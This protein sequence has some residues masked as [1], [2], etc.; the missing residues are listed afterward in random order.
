MK[1][2]L[3]FI[4]VV[5]GFLSCEK[6][7]QEPKATMSKTAVFESEQGIELYSNS[8]YNLLPTASDIAYSS[9][10]GSAASSAPGG[11]IIS[12]Y[13]VRR[14]VPD[15]IRPGAF[16]ARQSSGWDWSQ[17]RNIN[18]FIENLKASSL[19]PEVK[20]NYLGLAR[21]FRAWF[22]FQKVLRF[23]DVPWITKA[24]DVSDPDLFK[25]RDSRFLVMDSLLVDID[26]AIDNI[27]LKEDASR[28]LITKYI[29]LAFKS[30]V[31]LFEGTFRKYHNDYG[32]QGTSNQWLEHAANAAKIV[33]DETNFS[34]HQGEEA[35][36]E[37][38]ISNSPIS[39]EVML[40]THYD[41]GLGILHAANWYWTSATYGVRGSFSRTFVNT[42]LNIDGTP[43]TDDPEYKTT[44]FQEETKNR[45]LR[46]K[47]TI[48]TKDYGRLNGGVFSLSS[49]LFS[50]TYTGYQPIKWVLNDTYY[51][52][53][54]YNDN[55]VP[56]FRYAEILLNY[57]EAKAELGNLTSSDW[58]LTVGELRR[59]AGISNTNMPSH[60]DPYLQQ[61]YF[62]EI[63]DPVLLEVRRERGIELVMEGF[64]FNDLLR[65]KKG[66][67]LEMVWNG[68]YVSSLNTYFDLNEDGNPDVYFYKAPL[69]EDEIPGVSYVNVSPTLSS[70]AV[71]PFKLKNDDSGEIIWLDNMPR[72]WEQKNYFY[73]IPESDRLINPEIG[74][75]PGWEE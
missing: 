33:M 13:M 67:L 27:K 71:N 9:G 49:P 57:A 16:G 19:P 28:S 24:M 66:E 21:F 50:Y 36:R 8:F 12:D 56:I 2:I 41:L 6:L 51:D 45:D 26:F 52:G 43:F 11:D 59:R 48:R 55:I 61:N 44:V 42:Y 14:D 23:G 47:Q 17:L 68:M 1:K 4:I 20:S 35:Y 31:C 60:V 5:I 22:Y 3:I 32:L 62:P 39:S 64:R 46:L 25:G 10:G 75:N 53:G 54:A 40:A 63:S 30:R 7:D 69:E 74:Q 72:V 37:L 34:L 18:F 38:F 58:D 73:P 70:G 15:F 65:W 29:A